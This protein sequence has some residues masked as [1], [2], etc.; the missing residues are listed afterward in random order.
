MA[1]EQDQAQQTEDDSADVAEVKEDTT[2]I[3]KATDTSEAFDKL[4]DENPD[5]EDVE[6][7]P[8]EEKDD[9][10]KDS[11]KPEE[12][13]DTKADDKDAGKDSDKE[14]DDKDA[15][16][17]GD[18][19]TKVSDELTK[20]AID[21][22][23]TEEE[24]EKFNS[25]TELKKFLDVLEKV[26][27]EEDAVVQADSTHKPAEKKADAAEDTGIKFE[28]EGDI[29]PEILKAVRT[30]EQQNKELRETVGKLAGNVEQEQKARQLEGQR[31]FVKRFD[32]YVDKLGIDFADVLGKGKLNDLSKRSQAYKNRD[33]LRGR[34][35][36]FGQGFIA[37]KEAIPDEQKLFDMALNS[38][39]D[40]KVKRSSGLRL[41]EKTDKHA[42]SARV[43][44]AS[45]RKT[46]KLTGDQKA[47]TTN[48]AF[49]ELIDTTED[50][51]D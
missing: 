20:R 49:D 11:K 21:Q 14:G 19:E 39:H 31:Q 32:G 47:L 5:P 15:D 2:A 29:D 27:A 36:A 43:G 35:Y 13:D 17:S 51:D 40:D 41:K 48:L 1:K 12:K 38:L 10:K 3:D 37:A 28:N 4:I 25:D 34:M 23:F 46:G 33:A 45:T 9:E 26:V 16:K 6:E 7:T 8:P 18:D 24:I 44:R 42:K 50:Y 30:I 22:G